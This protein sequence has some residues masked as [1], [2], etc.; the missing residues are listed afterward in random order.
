MFLKIRFV[1]SWT[2]VRN[3]QSI[4]C[5]SDVPRRINGVGGGRIL[6]KTRSSILGE[7][8]K[9]KDTEKCQLIQN[10]SNQRKE[11]ISTVSV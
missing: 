1:E 5:A 10:R 7:P 8:V 4:S 6:K 11:R 3:S 9:I 2:T